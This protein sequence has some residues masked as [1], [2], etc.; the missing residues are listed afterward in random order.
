MNDKCAAGTGRFLEMMANTLGVTLPA[1]FALAA[2]GGNTRV[3]SLCAVFAE[4]EV[5]SLMSNGRSREDIAYG[6]CES[7]VAKVAALAGKQGTD[8]A[9]FLSG[10]LCESEYLRRRLAEALGVEVH[11]TPDARYAGALG[12]AIAAA[13]QRRN[14]TPDAIP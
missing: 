6:V 7:I 4:S 1:L 12:A 14:A 9:Y 11:T 13:A 8:K 10:G 3:S 5:I 2:N